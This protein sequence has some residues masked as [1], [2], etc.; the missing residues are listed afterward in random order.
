MKMHEW[1]FAT[2]VCGHCYLPRTTYLSIYSTEIRAQMAIL[3][4]CKVGCDRAVEVRKVMMG[5]RGRSLSGRWLGE[6]QKTI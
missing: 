3:A 6:E 2:G 1:G 5:K 4:R